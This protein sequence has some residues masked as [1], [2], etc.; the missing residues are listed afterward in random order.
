VGEDL[1]LIYLVMSTWESLGILVFN[2]E[3]TI[4]LVDLAF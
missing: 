2:R 1:K 4:G 3:I